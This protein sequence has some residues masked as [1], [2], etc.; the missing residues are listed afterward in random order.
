MS[1][2]AKR[3]TSLPKEE[4]PV[5]V[6]STWID[7][8][9]D[10]YTKADRVHVQ[11]SRGPNAAFLDT[12]VRYRVLKK[13]LHDDPDDPTTR[14]VRYYVD[15]A[16]RQEWPEAEFARELWEEAFDYYCEER[17]KAEEDGRS[18][19]RLLCQLVVKDASGS[20]LADPV[21]HLKPEPGGGFE[22]LDLDDEPSEPGRLAPSERRENRRE[23][24]Q[25]WK[26]LMSSAERH[27]NLER[28][29]SAQV[30]SRLAQVDNLVAQKLGVIDLVTEIRT[31]YLDD[32][33]AT[34]RSDRMMDFLESTRDM[35]LPYVGPG[36]AQVFGGIGGW[37]KAGSLELASML[38]DD[39]IVRLRSAIGDDLTDDL[40]AI[41]RSAAEVTEEE[42]RERLRAVLGTLIEERTKNP[43]G[44]KAAGDI[45]GEE[46][47][48]K[49]GELYMKLQSP[50]G[51]P[52]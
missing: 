35:L 32:M 52:G 25:L 17:S 19:R 46:F 42:Q 49:V 47:N 28:T 2:S 41:L 30:E 9:V 7:A 29:V 44:M 14:V 22:V 50:S 20:V 48:R 33:A 26:L 45:L 40:V 18:L 34:I 16:T 39:K 51:A 31:Q 38:S 6:P 4:R 37:A 13:E 36:L 3:K 27:E 10:C 1:P 12:G 23:R 5:R 11:C 43:E 8:L 24:A 21:G 15:D